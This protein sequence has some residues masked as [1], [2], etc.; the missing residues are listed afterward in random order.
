[1]Q[2]KYYPSDSV[3]LELSQSGKSESE[4]EESKTNKLKD[5]IL[6]ESSI[7]DSEFSSDQSDQ[8]SSEDEKPNHP[9]F[10][11]NNPLNNA[12]SATFY[13][14]SETK[15]IKKLKAK[16]T[17]KSKK[18][19][20]IAKKPVNNLKSIPPAT[21]SFTIKKVTYQQDQFEEE[22]IP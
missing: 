2:L 13:S 6:V 15:N 19:K 17:K 4:D 11:N 3:I 16:K 10:K 21:A 1:M 5:C 14:V 9:G 12:A 22:K 18:R 8:E 20:P 7:E